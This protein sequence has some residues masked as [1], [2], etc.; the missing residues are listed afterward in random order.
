MNECRKLGPSECFGADETRLGSVVQCKKSPRLCC[1]R[2]TKWTAMR[3][4]FCVLVLVERPSLVGYGRED[5]CFDPVY[6]CVHLT[7]RSAGVAGPRGAP[8]HHWPHLDY[9]LNVRACRHNK[10]DHSSG[11]S[12]SVTLHTSPYL[13][14]SVSVFIS[15]RCTVNGTGRIH[16]DS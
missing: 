15:G 1:T 9:L 6:R 8:P 12:L 4:Q 11:R 5:G 7:S 13:P 16:G 14:V 10:P 3:W 2:R